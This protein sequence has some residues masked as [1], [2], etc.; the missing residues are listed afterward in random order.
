MRA[1]RLQESTGINVHPTA[2]VHPTAVLEG[3]VTVGPYSY[4]GSHVTLHGDITIGAYTY[5]G[6]GTAMVGIIDIGAEV[7]ICLN[8]SLRGAQ[9]LRI[10]SHV[11]IFDNVNIESG[12]GWHWQ[13]ESCIEDWCWINHGAVMHG[14]A[15]REGA[16]VGM[17]ATLN[18]GSEVGRDAIIGDGAA[19]PVEMLIPEA[20]LAQGVPAG[21]AAQTLTSADRVRIM[22]LDTREIIRL[23][24]KKNI[25][26]G[27]CGWQQIRM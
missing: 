10:G 5:I 23:H 8:C 17:G 22:G 7:N 4:V 14:A 18:Y 21:I 12:R 13:D 9:R 16:V 19:V 25:E 11:S 6:A 24:G 15:V 26:Q 20:A 27:H 1:D 2:K 3:N